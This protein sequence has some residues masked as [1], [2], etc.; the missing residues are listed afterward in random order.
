MLTDTRVAA[1]KPPATGQ[2]EH[3]DIKVKGLRLRVGATGTKTWIVRR[4]V[5]DKVINRK[6]GTYPAMSLANAR[7]VGAAL[8][9]ALERDGSTEGIDRTFGEV[10]ATW[11]EKVAKG[12]NDLWQSQ[13]RQL[14][15]HVYPAWKDRKIASIKRQ[16]VR[17]L[18]DGLEGKVLPNRILALVRV[19]FRWALSRDIVETSPVEGLEK[20]RPETQRDRWLTMAEI[21]QLWPAAGLLGFPFGPFVKLLLLTGQRRSEVG[22]MRW[23]DID[24]AEKTWALSA[25]DTKAHRAHVVPLSQAALDILDQLPRFG[26]FVFTTNGRTPVSG[27]SK[28]KAQLDAYI[29]SKSDPLAP[30]RL[31]DLRRTAATH[32]VRLGVTETI[33]G[34][35]L[36]HAPQGVTAQVYALH[37]YA[38]EKRHALELWAAALD[39]AVNGERGGNVVAIN[40]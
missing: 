25:A 35:V 3:P 21:K 18:I 1:I 13:Q 20:P 12:R 2:A 22:E 9:E 14:E 19:I 31:H 39:G 26:E 4:R 24:L 36:N 17:A 16:D 8:I 40:G 6:L 5:G 15:L 30:W 23:A 33:V 32:L 27:F 7:T 28:A 29:A 10:A 38:A 11:I 37:S 34:R